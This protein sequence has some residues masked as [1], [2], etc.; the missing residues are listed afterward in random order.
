[1]DGYQINGFVIEYFIVFISF[2]AVFFFRVFLA[3]FVN[4][5]YTGKI[6]SVIA[7]VPVAKSQS[8]MPEPDYRYVYHYFAPPPAMSYF[9]ALPDFTT[10][11]CISREPS[12]NYAA[13]AGMS[14]VALQ[15]RNTPC[16][17]FRYA[18]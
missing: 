5:A 7:R 3:F 18:V 12:V 6:C 17:F 16:A 8:V 10:S 15:F 4:V 13:L 9:P 2:G 1:M 11:I 14:R